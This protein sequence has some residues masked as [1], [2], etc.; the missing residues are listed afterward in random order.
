M[1]SSHHHHIRKV[2]AQ[3]PFPI[4]DVDAVNEAFCQWRE[5]DS[6][7]AHHRVVLWTYCFTLRYFLLKSARGDLRS[8]SDLDALVDKAYTK[9]QRN[10]DS[11]KDALRY[12]SWVSVICKNVFLN[13]VRQDRHELSIHDEHGPTLTAEAP[14]TT[15]DAGFAVQLMRSAIA[16]LPPY[17]QEPAR[18]YFI[19]GCT[20]EEISAE[21]DK[22]L[23]TVR[24]YKHKAVRRFR[25]DEQLEELLR[26]QAR[27]Q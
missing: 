15:Y 13:Y 14:T 17:L 10:W 18:L 24:T 11:V 23:P 26:Q 16:Q 19:D 8:A 1:A 27:G 4:D 12:A 5:T 20:Y 2:A 7:R 3:L 9:V 6:E 21:I 22:P 25:E